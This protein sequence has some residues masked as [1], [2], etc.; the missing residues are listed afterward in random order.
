VI[1]KP[2]RC[3]LKN[4][5]GVPAPTPAD[6]A[7]ERRI[8]ADRRR[9]GDR[10]T[11]ERRDYDCFF[12]VVKLKDPCTTLFKSA[13]LC[14]FVKTGHIC[15]VVARWR[16]LCYQVASFFPIGVARGLSHV[17]RQLRLRLAARKIVLL[18]AGVVSA[19]AGAPVARADLPSD[20]A[21]PRIPGYPRPLKRRLPVRFVSSKTRHPYLTNR[22]HQ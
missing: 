3:L 5:T 19:V 11:H 4:S 22:T 21:T 15:K 6:C 20:Q 18:C 12:R 17:Y 14:C 1:R 16:R 13:V 2:I 10:A 8:R 9:T 7:G